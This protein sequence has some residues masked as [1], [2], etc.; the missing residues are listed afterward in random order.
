MRYDYWQPKSLFWVIPDSILTWIV[1][2]GDLAGV[3]GQI[4]GFL[5]WMPLALAALL[6]GV[7]LV[8]LG[9]LLARDS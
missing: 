6:G 4:V 3:S 2:V 9:R 1:T 5:T 7:C 8:L